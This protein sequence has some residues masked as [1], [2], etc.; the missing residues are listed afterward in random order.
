[1]LYDYANVCLSRLKNVTETDTWGAGC[2]GAWCCS[3]AR[4]CRNLIR[5]ARVENPRIQGLNIF[6]FLQIKTQLT[7]DVMLPV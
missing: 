5:G 3:G 7:A 1:M 4:P 2:G 6:T